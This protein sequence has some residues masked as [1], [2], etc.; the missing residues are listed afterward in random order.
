[1][2]QPSAPT[3]KNYLTVTDL[4]M[5]YAPLKSVKFSWIRSVTR[6]RIVLLTLTVKDLYKKFHERQIDM[7][8]P[9]RQIGS[10]AVKSAY[11]A[12]TSTIASNL[13][14]QKGAK[15]PFFIMPKTSAQ[16]LSFQQQS[17]VTS[18]FFTSSRAIVYD[19]RRYHSRRPEACC[20]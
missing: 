11:D 13:I 16:R 2:Y 1:M 10:S 17:Q 15:T 4:Y 12:K 20:W 14:P 5:R 9:S 8:S 19:Y 18:S 3:S 7:R 6:S